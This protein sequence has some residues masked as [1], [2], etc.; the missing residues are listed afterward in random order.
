MIGYCLMCPK[1]ALGNRAPAGVTP[2]TNW[3]LCAFK[4]AA[5]G[6]PRAGLRQGFLN[7][8]FAPRQV[9][10]SLPYRL[11]TP[12]C[13]VSHRMHRLAPIVLKNGLSL[14]SRCSGLSGTS[15]ASDDYRFG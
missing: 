10:T 11:F 3:D 7:V 2:C 14:V 9:G 1:E 8:G 12:S 6:F 13:A 4:G 5:E 15:A